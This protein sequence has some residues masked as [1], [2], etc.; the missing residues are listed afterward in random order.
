MAGDIT[1]QQISA[2]YHEYLKFWTIEKQTGYQR[3]SGD[4]LDIIIGWLDGN[5]AYFSDHPN[6]GYTAEYL[7]AWFKA[8][9]GNMLKQKILTVRILNNVGFRKIIQICFHLGHSNIFI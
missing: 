8:A 1:Y 3:I 5:P 4:T 9:S 2:L 7:T 6:R